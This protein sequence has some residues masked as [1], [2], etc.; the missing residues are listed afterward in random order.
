MAPEA[1]NALEHC[2][3][4]PLSA[5][6]LIIS[7]YSTLL[8]IWVNG[9]RKQH[10]TKQD[11]V[12]RAHHIPGPLS[13]DPWDPQPGCAPNHSRSQLYPSL[14]WCW[15]N[16]A[17]Q[18]FFSQE[19][20]WLVFHTHHPASLSCNW[21][22]FLS[23]WFPGVRRADFNWFAF[24]VVFQFVRKDKIKSCPL[25][26]SLSTVATPAEHVNL[27]SSTD[28]AYSM[29]S[30]WR[31]VVKHFIIQ[32]ALNCPEWGGNMSWSSSWWTLAVFHHKFAKCELDLATA[33]F[34]PIL[35][36]KLWT[37]NWQ[38][39]EGINS[40]YPQLGLKVLHKSLGFLD[41]GEMQLALLP[42][43]DQ[44]GKFN[45]QSR[46]Q[47]IDGLEV[48]LRFEGGLNVTGGEERE[49]EVTHFLT[50]PGLQSLY[51]ELEAVRVCSVS[52]KNIDGWQ[53]VNQQFFSA[54]C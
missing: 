33:C 22:V 17:V 28:R 16:K 29:G 41:F 43:V 1:E 19:M 3:A 45:R 14:C 37:G 21:A 31:L 47:N 24:S 34:I 18:A 12:A 20:L 10:L 5:R 11:S 42:S 49:G 25:C 51:A 54:Y 8:W 2:W 23:L 44:A 35:Q 27:R 50:F 48:A 6:S 30:I 53:A 13:Q 9:C 38:G 7:N 32:N 39:I 26:P 52:G 46:I 15:A 36:G 40:R 4:L